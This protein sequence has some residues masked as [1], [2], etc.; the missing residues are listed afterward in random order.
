MRTWT[1]KLNVEKKIKVVRLEKKFTDIPEGSKMLVATPLI[2]D[3]YVRKIPKGHSTSFLTMRED[4]ARE[5]KADKTC[6]VSTGI[7][8]RISAEAAY[9]NF[10]L[11]ASDENI[12]PF[13]RVIDETM[14][15]A[16]KT[17]LRHR[18]FTRT[19]TKRR[20]L[21]NQTIQSLSEQKLCELSLE[22]RSR[23]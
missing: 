12:T 14:K 20:A 19:P 4:L 3:A 7:F 23:G 2:V 9:E 11:S 13:W 10:L 8:L 6:P 15:V 17:Y 1:E 16:K 18:V 5:Y 21:M 22:S